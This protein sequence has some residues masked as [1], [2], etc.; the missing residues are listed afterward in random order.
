MPE[1]W[2]YKQY[3]DKRILV[4]TASLLDPLYPDARILCLSAEEVALLRPLLGYAHR[5]STFV[6]QY[7]ASQYVAPST[8]EWDAIQAIVAGLEDKLMVDCTDFYTALQTIA[9][10]IAATNARLE[11]LNTNVAGTNT[12]ITGTYDELQ[13]MQAALECI[14]RG[15]PNTDDTAAL[16]PIIDEYLDDGTF[17]VDDPYPGQAGPGTESD[18]CAIAQLVWAFSYEMLTEVIQPAQT[19]ALAVLLPAAVLAITGWLGGVLV[20]VPVG[21]IMYYL[22][23][24]IDAWARGSLDGVV[25]SWFTLKDELVCAA[26]DELKV[27][28][29]YASA[30]AAMSEVINEQEDISPI[31]KVV[32]RAFTAPWVFAKMAYA[33]DQLTTW[34][35]SRVTV[36]FC[37]DCPTDDIIGSNWI[38]VPWPWEGMP[39]HFDH[40]G[41]SWWEVHCATGTIPAGFR[42]S[43]LFYEIKNFTGT[44]TQLKKMSGSEACAV[45]TSMFNNTSEYT[46]TNGWYFT[47]LTGEFDYTECKAAVRPD[48]TSSTLGAKA[49]SG[50]VTFNYT[51]NLGYTCTGSCDIY[52]RYL[53]FNGTTK[54]T[55]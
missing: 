9:A 20:A 33:W 45:G 16:P 3:Y 19:G 51:W 38:A 41:G 17:D 14:C 25:N 18:A 8:E 46:I 37:A 43:G 7:Q 39:I 55:W 29:S 24:I 31:D 21:A 47:Y 54:P 4:E 1:T 52:I 6:S 26:Y 13:A 53:V 44:C 40:G 35:T 23:E 30:A 36:G 11:T 10:N 27:G 42:L 22:R 2:R 12:A 50:P 15:M 34:A 5:R 48:A 49:V 32:F 28:A